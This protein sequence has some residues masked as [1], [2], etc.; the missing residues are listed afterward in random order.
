MMLELESKTTQ[1]STAT[2]K[3]GLRSKLPVLED[4]DFGIG[5][6]K[7]IKTMADFK[8]GKKNKGKN[9]SKQAPKIDATDVMKGIVEYKMSKETAEIILKADK[10]KKAPQ[11]VLCDYVNTQY[12]LLG[13]CVRVLTY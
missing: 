9:K 11:E 7:E 4:S 8:T 13:Y 5:N 6:K 2:I 3:R 10:T 1:R 12:G